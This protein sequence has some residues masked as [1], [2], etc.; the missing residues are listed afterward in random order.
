MFDLTL[1]F[2][3]SCIPKLL[4][5]GRFLAGLDLFV[6]SRVSGLD[7]ACAE[8]ENCRVVG[9]ECRKEKTKTSC[10]TYGCQMRPKMTQ[11]NQR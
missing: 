7:M 11:S 8:L 1:A 2:D 5:A 10:R 4:L 3:T 6:L 9:G